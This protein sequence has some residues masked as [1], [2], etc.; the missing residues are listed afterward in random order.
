LWF[1]AEIRIDK[2]Y[3]IEWSIQQEDIHHIKWHTDYDTCYMIHYDDHLDEFSIKD[4]AKQ[5][6]KWEIAV[7]EEIDKRV[8]RLGLSAD[9]NTIQCYCIWTLLLIEFE[10]DMKQIYSDIMFF[11][12]FSTLFY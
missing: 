2:V 8:D 6:V 12:H 4:P 3:E 5:I 10:L 9:F 1:I 7:D 11:K